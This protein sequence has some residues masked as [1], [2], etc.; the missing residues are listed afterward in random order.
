MKT[1]LKNVLIEEAT[2]K[3]QSEKLSKRIVRYSCWMLGIWLGFVIVPICIIITDRI[4]FVL[5]TM[6]LK[7]LDVMIGMIAIWFLIF[8]FTV[9]PMINRLDNLEQGKK[10]SSRGQKFVIKISK[11]YE[12]SEEEL[13]ELAKLHIRK[14]E[15]RKKQA[16][17]AQSN[18]KEEQETL[19]KEVKEL[20]DFIDG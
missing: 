16:E 19:E 12:P 13:K 15:E 9:S 5:P 6:V 20:E 8:L 1:E 7:R 3:Y 18:A 2:R 11:N 4:G 14:K 17:T 10:L